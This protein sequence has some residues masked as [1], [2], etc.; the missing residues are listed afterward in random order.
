ML[1]DIIL[2]QLNPIPKLPPYNSKI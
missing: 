2:I 1:L